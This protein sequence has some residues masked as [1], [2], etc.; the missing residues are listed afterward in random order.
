MKKSMRLLSM[1]M[2]MVLTMVCLTSCGSSDKSVEGTYK[3]A[4]IERNGQK[5]EIGSDAAAQIG[6]TDEFMVINLGK[7][8]KGNIKYQGTYYDLSYNH[9]GENVELTVNGSAQPATIKDGKIT[10]ALSGGTI[11]LKKVD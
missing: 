9:D 8:N 4:S 5:V 10:I 3:T 6:L 1:A 11:V 2:A 7:D